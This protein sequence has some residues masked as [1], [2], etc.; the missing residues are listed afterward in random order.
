MA[1]PLMLDGGSPSSR[2]AA[3]PH[4]TRVCNFN[5]ARNAASTASLSAAASRQGMPASRAPSTSPRLRLRGPR[6]ECA[7]LPLT[8]ASASRRQPP[9]G[10]VAAAKFEHQQQHQ[11]RRWQRREEVLVEEVL[12]TCSGVG[13]SGRGVGPR[14]SGHPS[15]MDGS[16]SHSR[17]PREP[18]QASGSRAED[19]YTPLHREVEAFVRAMAPTEEE[20][21]AKREVVESV[22]VAACSAFPESQSRL[23]VRLF[24]SFAN[25]LATWDS[26]VD[27]VIT[28]I[29]APSQRTGAYSERDRN[30]V[31]SRLR[32]L[33]DTMRQL[34]RPHAAQSTVVARARIPILKLR[35]RNNVAVDVSIGDGSAVNAAVY[36]AGQARSYPPLGPL[37]ATL[38]AYLKHLGLAD[39]ATGGLG[40]YSLCNMVLAHLQEELKAGRDIFDLGE[41]LYSF[42]LR[43]SAEFDYERDAVSVRCGGVVPRDV[44]KCGADGMGFVGDGGGARRYGA[45]MET[46]RWQRLCVDCPLSG[47]DVA[48]GTFRIRE[49]ADA[50]AGGARSL[51][52]AAH[53]MMHG[54]ASSISRGGGGGGAGSGARGS[55]SRAGGRG[56]GNRDGGG[57]R[58]ASLL[59]SLFDLDHA[60]ARNVSA[61]RSPY[62][63]VVGGN[64]RAA[65]TSAA[66]SAEDPD[67][68]GDELLALPT[69]SA[70]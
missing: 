57:G 32:K 2:A 7:Q 1:T 49:V 28:G 59:S 65:M 31:A 22:R 60:L 62:F 11:Q 5:A 45:G 16:R 10:R 23:D 3:L 13:T 58:G 36:I 63:E 24:G 8:A 34:R 27:L 68:Y 48:G 42:L 26:D 39:V 52:A 50:F 47:H 15:S 9:A 12:G 43:Y 6:D 25:G 35:T 29:H 66:P 38:R 44:L 19:P 46:L 21:A 61:S 56:S 14:R 18:A 20:Q 69:L 30:R 70:R 41:S 67:E 51:E 55:S 33:S 54:H 40:S 37:V 53:R 64:E 17:S 4:V